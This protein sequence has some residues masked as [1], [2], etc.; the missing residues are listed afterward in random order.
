MTNSPFAPIHSLLATLPIAAINDATIDAIC[1][2]TIALCDDDSIT[3]DD[4]FALL[5]IIDDRM[6]DDDDALYDL[7]AELLDTL[8]DNTDIRLDI[9]P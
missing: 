5:R 4:C 7:N 6:T 2:L 1:T 9:L 8:R 3:A